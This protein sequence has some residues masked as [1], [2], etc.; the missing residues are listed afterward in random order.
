MIGRAF[1]SQV[2]SLRRPRVVLGILGATVGA[3]VLATALA[4]GTAG[5]AAVARGPGAG[6]GLSDVTGA[7]GIVSGVDFAATL[8]GAIAFSLAA[9]ML[10]GEFTAGT[11]RNLLIR[12]PRRIPLLAGR[13]LAI[14]TLAA[15]SALVAVAAT[16]PAALAAAR[17]RGL[18][19][20]AWWTSE[21][22]RALAEAGATL[23]AAAAGYALLGAAAG[24]LLRSPTLAIAIGLAWMLP[25]ESI[26]TA[27]W[28]DAGRLLP[29]SLLTAV[30][31]GGTGDV[32][33]GAATIGALAWIAV[34]TGLAWWTFSRRDVTS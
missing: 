23:P 16:V 10:G 14:A 28:D 30:A 9:A 25:V 29:G 8:I 19:V 3:M 34:L 7:T 27:T 24:V 22:M 32:A 1:M 18:E 5:D 17:S 12:L 6:V 33:M 4:I 11:I 21:G 2:V 26:L 20:S 13:T 31:Q 15:L